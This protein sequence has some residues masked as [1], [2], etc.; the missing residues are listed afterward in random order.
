MTGK[1]RL[2]VL[3]RQ[4]FKP[5]FFLGIRQEYIFLYF[6]VKLSTTDRVSLACHNRAE[7]Q[8]NS[9]MAMAGSY[10][11]KQPYVTEDSRSVRLLN[12]TRQVPRRAQRPRSQV[13]E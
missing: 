6:F 5:K 10:F 2:R 13:G 3:F 4:A 1:Q 9:H 8:G 7:Q 11:R 12:L